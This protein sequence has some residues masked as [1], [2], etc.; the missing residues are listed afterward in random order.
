MS[1]P[2]NDGIIIHGAVSGQVV[3]KPRGSS[4]VQGASAAATNVAVAEVLNRL[5]ELQELLVAHRD[6]ITGYDAATRDVTDLRDEVT[7][8][9][10]DSDRIAD[11]LRRLVGRVGSLT[12]L[13][14][15]SDKLV[16]AVRA[17][18]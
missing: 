9:D 18:F 15:A 3:N 12:A 2:N 13:A 8:D 5:A 6:Q 17:I 4:I 1:T 7:R 11:T 16:E 14:V 10:K